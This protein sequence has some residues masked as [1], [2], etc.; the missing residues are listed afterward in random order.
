MQ[1]N[2]AIQKTIR[3]KQSGNVKDSYSDGK[4]IDAKKSKWERNTNKRDF[5]RDN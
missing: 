4:Q 5:S 2:T 3:T 1:T